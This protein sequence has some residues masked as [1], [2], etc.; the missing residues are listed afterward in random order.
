MLGLSPD[1]FVNANYAFLD[2]GD[3]ATRILCDYA[4]IMLSGGGYARFMPL[5]VEVLGSL[6]HVSHLTGWVATAGR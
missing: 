2:A 3:Y 5:Y 6:N 4:E 1:A